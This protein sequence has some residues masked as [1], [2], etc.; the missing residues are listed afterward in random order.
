MRTPTDLAR[1]TL[2]PLVFGGLAATCGWYAVRGG[3]WWVLLW[4]AAAFAGAA[5]VYLAGRPGWLGKRADGTRNPAAAALFLPYTLFALAA[6][7]AHRRAGGD[8][9]RAWDRCG[10]TLYLARRPLPGELPPAFL[11]E[12]AAEAP[13][14]QTPAAVV[15]DLTAEFRDP[16]AVRA[17]PGYRCVPILDAAAPSAADL[18]R[19]VSRLPP[20]AGPPL[21]IHCANGRGRTGLVAA[22]WLLAHGLAGNPDDALRQL[23][24]ARPRVRLLPRQQAALEAFAADRSARAI[25]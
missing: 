4:P 19:I 23:R 20:P 17:Q 15:L 16:A 12:P 2:Y 25:G 22:A 11:A 1:R 3:A 8:G 18:R 7:H 9:R 5:A 6:W 10:E 14:A 13:A 21:L 24:A